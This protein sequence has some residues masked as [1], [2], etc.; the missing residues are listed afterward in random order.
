MQIFP[1]P[2]EFEWDKG[3]TDKN[4]IKHGVQNQEIEE[5]FFNIP[6]LVIGYESHSVNEGRFLILGTTDDKKKLSIIFTIRTGRIRVISARPMSKKER[7]LYE[8]T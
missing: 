1:I 6:L 2:T 3:N 8:K 4:K 5:V 7:E